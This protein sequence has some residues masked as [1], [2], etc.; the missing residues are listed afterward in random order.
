M[1]AVERWVY[2]RDDGTII[3]HEENDGWT[4]LRRGPEAHEE[5]VTLDDLRNY[6]RLLEDA[7]RLLAARGRSEIP[8]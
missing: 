8:E 6:P 5:I 7:Q 3:L 1:G 2:V 4:F